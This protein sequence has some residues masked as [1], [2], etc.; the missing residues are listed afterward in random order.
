MPASDPRRF[1]RQMGSMLVLSVVAWVAF[2]LFFRSFWPGGYAPGGALGHFWGWL[3]AGTVVFV[4]A[5]ITLFRL[6]ETPPAWRGNAAIALTA[7]AL[8]LDVLT[9][10]FFERWFPGASAGDDRIYPALIVG[11]VGTILLVSLFITNPEDTA[12]R[13]PD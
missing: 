9:T 11:V 12:S 8:C 10:I 13:E 7:P 5:T 1:R 2:A 6:F 4:I 3:G